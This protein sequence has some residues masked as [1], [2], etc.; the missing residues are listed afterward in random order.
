MLEHLLP[1]VEQIPLLFI[2]V[3][4]SDPEC[5]FWQVQ[6][7]VS[8]RYKQRHSEIVL[9]P[10]SPTE[11]ETLILNLLGAWLPVLPQRRTES[12]SLAE[13][14]LWHVLRRTDGNP[15]FVEEILRALIGRGSLVRDA[16]TATW[17]TRLDTAGVAVSDTLHG[18]LAARIDAL[19][20]APRRVLRLAAVIGRIFSYRL[21]AEVCDDATTLDGASAALAA[22][23]LD[24]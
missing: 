2:C 17:D 5:G 19:P 21:L 22:R 9:Q 15:F 6:E 20:E 3:L 24:P 23:R 14:F 12:A 4:R 7:R 16:S 13:G 1:L 8:Q 18:V 10:L 11:T